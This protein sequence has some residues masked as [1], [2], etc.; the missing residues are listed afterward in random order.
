MRSVGRRVRDA[1]FIDQNWTRIQIVVCCLF[2]HFFLSKPLLL[3]VIVIVYLATFLSK[4]FLLSKLDKDSDCH[5]LFQPPLLWRQSSGGLLGGIH[6]KWHFWGQRN[7]HGKVPHSCPGGKSCKYI[8]KISLYKFMWYERNP[9]LVWTCPPFWC[10]GR[11]SRGCKSSFGPPQPYLP[12]CSQPRK[13]ENIRIFW[14][15]LLEVLSTELWHFAERLN[16]KQLD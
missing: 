6:R 14:C 4:S 1:V 2:F 7:T 11:Q 8:S 9:P 10:P 5:C 3:A 16:L 12:S 13:V 15:N